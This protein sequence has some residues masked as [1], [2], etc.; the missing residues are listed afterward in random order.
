MLAAIAAASL[1][2][3]DTALAQQSAVDIG[4]RL[5]RIEAAHGLAPR[6]AEIARRA[7]AVWVY[8]GP[9]GGDASRISEVDRRAANA[10]VNDADVAP[11][12]GAL[13][14]MVQAMTGGSHGRT[15]D[16]AICRFALEAAASGSR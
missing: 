10:M 14:E 15:P 5:S 1:T 2:C 9:C 7:A 16:A 12:P 8:I 11:F 13:T 3:N 4:E 6:D